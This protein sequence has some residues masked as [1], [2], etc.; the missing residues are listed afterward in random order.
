MMIS[1]SQYLFFMAF[2]AVLVLQFQPVIVLSFFALRLLIQMIIF[3]K[4]MKQLAEKDL[5]LLAP[6]IE[7]SLLFIYPMIS[8]SNMFMKKNK[9]K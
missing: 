5:L 9:W 4:S 7:V 6:F 2:V 3:N 8:M 1:S